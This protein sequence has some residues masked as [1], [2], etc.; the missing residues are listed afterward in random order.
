[1]LQLADALLS[2]ICA[3]K[4]LLGYEALFGTRGKIF[5]LQNFQ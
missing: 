5:Y 3:A 1:V 2:G 4:L